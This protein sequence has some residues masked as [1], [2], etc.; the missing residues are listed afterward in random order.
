MEQDKLGRSTIRKV[1]LLDCKYLAKLDNLSI[2]NS[3]V[4][5]SYLMANVEAITTDATRMGHPVDRF[6][7]FIC[8]DYLII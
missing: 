6:D 8:K 3:N 4:L 2:L 7:S 1:N 5:T